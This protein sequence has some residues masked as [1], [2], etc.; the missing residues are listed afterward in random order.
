MNSDLEKIIKLDEQDVAASKVQDTATLLTLWDM[1]GRLRGAVERVKPNWQLIA[2]VSIALLLCCCGTPSPTATPAAGLVEYFGMTKPGLAPEVFAAGILPPEGAVMHSSPDFS[3]D[4]AEVYFSVYFP[5]Q[6]PRVDVVMF[7]EWDGD[8]WTAVQT[9]PFS[10]QFNDDW[11]WFSRDGDRIY[12]SSRRPN[13]AGGQV[14]DEYGLWYVERAGKGWSSP[15]RIAT[16]A[17][18]ER[19]EGTI[20]VAAILPGGYGDMDVYRLEY[21]DGTYSMPTNLGPAVNTEAEEYGPCAAPDGSYL[22]FTRFAQAPERSVGLYVS[23]WHQDGTWSEAQD[24]G[25]DIAACQGARFPTLSPDGKYLFF[26][27]EGGE[28]IYW[29]DAKVVEHMRS[30]G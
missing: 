2:L 21:V 9:A 24:M 20:Y 10:G 5:D 19:D 8:S 17:D 22:L 1:A 15:R 16:P 3:P 23:F 6:E 29:L 26:V 14:A 28:A 25:D 27:A 18:F 13:E 30:R 11:P 12:F 4:G 7:S